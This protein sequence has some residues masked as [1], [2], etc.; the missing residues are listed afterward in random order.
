VGQDRS[1]KEDS[2]DDRLH[3]MLQAD[4]GK[5]LAMRGRTQRNDGESWWLAW[6]DRRWTGGTQDEFSTLGDKD[7]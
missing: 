7:V 4:R 5:T 3:T 6:Q 1:Q 2:I